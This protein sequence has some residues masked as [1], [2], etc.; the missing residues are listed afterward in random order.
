MFSV[1]LPKAPKYEQLDNNTGRF[2]IEECYPGYGTTL[3]NSLRRVLLSSLGGSAVISAKIKG[4]THEFTTLKGVMEDMVQVILNL[5]QVRFKLHGVESAVATLKVKGERAVTAA[6]I[7]GTSEVEVVNPTQHIATLTSSA[8]ELEI[9]MK[10]EKGL[11]Y[12]PVEQQIREEKEIG[13]IA[14]D[15]IYTPVRRVNFVIDNMR[16]GKR[17]DYDKI[18]LDIVT[19]GTISPE[20]AYTQAVKILLDQFSSIAGMGAEEVALEETAV[21]SPIEVKAEV[22]AQAAPI[23]VGVENLKLSTRTSNVLEANNIMTVDQISAM[24]EVELRDLEGMGEKGIKEIKKAIGTLG[25]TLKSEEQ[26]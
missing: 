2:I 20:E 14:I 18:T 11:G 21:E 4:V 6:D 13:A 7:K 9:E 23:T 10:I 26:N 3:A 19:D 1:S 24:T 16:V 12:I 15:A 25:I 8:A 17:T 5:K 22:L